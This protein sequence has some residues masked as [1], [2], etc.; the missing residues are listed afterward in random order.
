MPNIGPAVTTKSDTEK[1]ISRL[2]W[3]AVPANKTQLDS[4]FLRSFGSFFFQREQYCN[5][6]LRS[7][8]FMCH[9]PDYVFAKTNLLA[10]KRRTENLRDSARFFFIVLRA[11]F[12]RAFLSQSWQIYVYNCI[13]NI[14]VLFLTSR[15]LFSRHSTP[16]KKICLFRIESASYAKKLISSTPNVDLG[17]FFSCIYFKN[18]SWKALVGG[19][20]LMS[21][22]WFRKRLILCTPQDVAFSFLNPR[23]AFL[24]DF[25]NDFHKNRIFHTHFKIKISLR[26]RSYFSSDTIDETFP[27]EANSSSVYPFPWTQRSASWKA[28]AK[29]MRRVFEHPTC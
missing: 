12:F 23:L 2:H 8:C 4:T 29:V 3:V 7:S 28:K 25:H 11:T 17:K 10:A 6:Q 26:V 27:T 16:G 13:G 9:I 20:R 21:G 19:K 22:C 14:Y 18:S 15:T 24:F 5:T 1:H